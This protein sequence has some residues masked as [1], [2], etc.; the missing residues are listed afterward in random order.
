MEI[1]IK[2]SDTMD[3]ES[4]WNEFYE[5]R[6]VRAPAICRDKY[7]LQIG[8]FIHLRNKNGGLMTLQIGEAFKEDVKR[9]ALA[10]YVVTDIFNQLH[11]ENQEIGEVERVQGITL[12]CDPEFFLVDKISNVLVDARRYT[13]KQGMVGH[14]GY[15]MEIRPA[16]SAN[17]DIVI[18]NIMSLFMLARKRLDMSPEGSRIAMIGASGIG[19]LT[20]GFHLHYGLPRPLLGWKKMVKDVARTM[21][22]AF[23]YY[24]GIPAIIPEG[25]DDI[26]RRTAT[27][28]SYGKPGGFNLDNRTFEYRMPGGSCL[29]HPILAKGLMALGAVVVEDLVSRLRVCTDMFTDLSKMSSIKDLLSLYPNLPDA[30][31]LYG[32]ICNFDINPARQHLNV[33][34]DDVRQM[35]GYEERAASI[36]PFFKCLVENAQFGNNIEDNWR[37]YYNEKRQGQMD[38]LPATVE[39]SAHG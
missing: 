1:T 31:T 21:T 8:D 10:A 25:N 18:D 9:N 17:V 13:R 6:I 4:S 22:T 34:I 12:G 38:F 3:K 14:D 11:L 33:V 37:G 5:H 16:A 19:H 39:A 20:A 2:I 36:E 15:L 30:L 23:D 26:V 24:I 29:R 32:I 28:L 35:V 27:F 7:D